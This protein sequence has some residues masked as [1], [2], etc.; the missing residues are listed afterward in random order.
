MPPQKTVK[1]LQAWRS[2]ECM[3]N[4]GAVPIAA[5]DDF[6]AAPFNSKLNPSECSNDDAA[7]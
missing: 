2:V 4:I 6:T 5:D 3:R 1:Q 7:C